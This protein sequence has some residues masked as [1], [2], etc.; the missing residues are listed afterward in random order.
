MS[1]FFYCFRAALNGGF[2]I[3][4]RTAHAYRVSYYEQNSEIGYDATIYQPSVDLK[5]KNDTEHYI[6]VTSEVDVENMKMWVRIYGTKDGRTVEVTKP[7][8]GPQIKPPETVYEDDPTLPKGQLVQIEYPAWGGTSVFKQI[9][10]NKD[11]SVR[12]EQE[13]KSYYRPWA[14]VFKKGTKD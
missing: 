6:L 2:P 3:T 12:F 13:F 4:E 14:A 5:F 1:G 9:V 7:K 8:L 10:K 11:G